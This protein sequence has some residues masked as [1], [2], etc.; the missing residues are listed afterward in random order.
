MPKGEHTTR[1]ERIENMSNRSTTANQQMLQAINKIGSEFNSLFNML[2]QYVKDLI[3]SAVGLQNIPDGEKTLEDFYDYDYDDVLNGISDYLLSMIETLKRALDVVQD[4]Q[5]DLNADDTA[6]ESDIEEIDSAVELM[7]D[8]IS[9]G[10]SQH[11]T[12]LALTKA[13]DNPNRYTD[14]QFDFFISVIGG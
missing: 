9:Y 8:L 10:G 13:V 2:P 14:E 1:E 12:A 6:D 3:S 4:I 7:E 11:G 5:A